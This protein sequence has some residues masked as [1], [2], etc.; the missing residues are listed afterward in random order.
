MMLTSVLTLTKEEHRQA[1]EEFIAKK[2]KH[3]IKDISY[4]FE[5]RQ[6]GMNESEPHAVKQVMI[7]LEIPL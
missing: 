6:S 7:A 3:R 5:Y 2:T 4:K 1:I